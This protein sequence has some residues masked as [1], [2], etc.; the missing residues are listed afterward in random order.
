MHIEKAYSLDSYEVL[1]AELAYDYYWHGHIKDKKNF[2]C[3]DKNCQA[4]I[5]CANLDKL[6]ENMK[7]DPHY[8]TVGGL[9]AH[10]SECTLVSE[11]ENH[12][13]ERR[14][15]GDIQ[16]ERNT[17]NEKLPDIFSFL[18]PK[19]QKELTKTKVVETSNSTMGHQRQTKQVGGSISKQPSTH[20]SVRSFV[21]KYFRYKKQNVLNQRY[22]N[23]KGYNISY[24]EMFFEIA[25]QDITAVSKYPRIY[26]GK[27]FIN[28]R[29]EDDYSA[30]FIS[31]FL[32][33]GELI[34]P[35]VYISKDL[36]SKAFTKKLSEDKFEALR[37]KN[38]PC[39]WV[40]VYSVPKIKMFQNKKY[41]NLNISKLDF[42]DL[43]DEIG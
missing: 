29:K 31:E 5:T 19:L 23:I 16:K 4:R 13:R 30:N 37:K 14:C 26:F 41:I 42:L 39:V 1:D 17:K 36:I 11:F 15:I 2:K 22:I 40:F 10:S 9:G 33:E 6:R 7:V 38:Y 8:K 25:G 18:R 24:D 27:A 21:T 32:L 3:P 35:S 12:N 28:Q 20:Y 34:K 43:R